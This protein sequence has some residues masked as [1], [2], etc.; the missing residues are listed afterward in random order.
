MVSGCGRSCRFC[1][2]ACRIRALRPSIQPDRAKSFTNAATKSR[3]SGS[4]SD[5]P[6][7]TPVGSLHCLVKWA[8]AIVNGDPDVLEA[9]PGRRR[10][11]SGGTRPRRST[12]L[13][14]A[15]SEASFGDT[16][17]ISPAALRTW[18]AL[19]SWRWTSAAFS[20]RAPSI[21]RANTLR[22]VSLA[23]SD[24]GSNAVCE[25]A[26]PR[27]CTTAQMGLKQPPGHTLGHHRVGS[28]DSSR[29]FSLMNSVQQLFPAIQGLFSSRPA[30]AL[31]YR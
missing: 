19:A 14:P 11:L 15:P 6:I 27:I 9:A 29:L 4:L 8:C 18:M 22:V 31:L 24:H 21:A 23:E 1:R 13:G 28:R 12:R 26:L 20:T 10:K 7:S 30:T 16:R 2:D 3:I 25:D 5:N 17:E